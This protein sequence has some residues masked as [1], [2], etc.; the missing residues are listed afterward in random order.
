MSAASDVAP[1]VIMYTGPVLGFL[2]LSSFLWINLTLDERRRRLV[3]QAVRLFWSGAA[4][5]ALVGVLYAAGGLG[6][7]SLHRVYA[8]LGGAVL[9]ASGVLALQYRGAGAAPPRALPP[10]IPRK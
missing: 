6:F 3:R 10:L 8:A 1:H 4:A 5:S 7:E 9:G 2:G